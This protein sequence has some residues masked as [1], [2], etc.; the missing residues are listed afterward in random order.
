MSTS[1]VYTLEGGDLLVVADNG[2]SE[3]V[4]TLVPEGHSA[5]DRARSYQALAET[6]CRVHARL[7]GRVSRRALEVAQGSELEAMG[8]VVNVERWRQEQSDAPATTHAET[9]VELRERIRVAAIDQCL[10]DHG[11]PLP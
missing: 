4:S 9:D 2:N 11:H 7:L 10:Y 5:Y 3:T 1:R 8:A 6:L